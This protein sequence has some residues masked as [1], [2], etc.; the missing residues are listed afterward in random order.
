MILRK[1]KAA[2][3]VAGSNE[4]INHLLFMDDLKLYNRNEK[5]LH[6]LVQT[7]CVF[8]KDIGMKFGIK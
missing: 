2:Y 7:I 6:S 1:A 5:E 8:S 3:E 4:K